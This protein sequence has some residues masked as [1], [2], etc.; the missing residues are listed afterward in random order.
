MRRIADETVCIQ[1]AL[2]VNL[3]VWIVVLVWEKLL[4]TK[5]KKLK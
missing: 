1:E 3:D 5:N 2:F 4:F